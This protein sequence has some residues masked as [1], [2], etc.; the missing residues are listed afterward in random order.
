[1]RKFKQWLD[2]EYRVVGT[3]NSRQRL[4]VNGVFAEYDDAMANVWI[5]HKGTRVSVG[6]GFTAEQRIW[7]G[8]RPE[9]IVSPHLPH[10]PVWPPDAN[11]S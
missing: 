11:A 4:A 9:E 5:K 2:A 6:S 1:M 10:L 8:Q 3:D 7:Y